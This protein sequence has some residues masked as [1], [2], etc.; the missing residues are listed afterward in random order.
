LDVRARAAHI[1]GERSIGSLE[2]RRL[3]QELGAGGDH[4]V[5]YHFAL[6][7]SLPQVLVWLRLMGRI[8]RGEIEP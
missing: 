7:L 8:Q 5:P 2:R 6:P 3:E 4:D 1:L